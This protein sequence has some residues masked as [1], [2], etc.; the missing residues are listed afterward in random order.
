MG[1][2]EVRDLNAMRV[3]QPLAT[4]HEMEVATHVAGL[5]LLAA[6][7]HAREETGT[8]PPDGEPFSTS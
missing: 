7:R 2:R 3:G 6:L 5:P 1:H 4:V 8:A